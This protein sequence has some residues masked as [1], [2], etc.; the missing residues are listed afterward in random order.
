MGG[1]GLSRGR[2]RPGWESGSVE[3]CGMG[4]GRVGESV[5]PMPG[6]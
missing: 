4:R 1:E 2:G 3:S 5:G 6:S